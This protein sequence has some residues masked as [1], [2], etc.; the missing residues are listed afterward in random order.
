MDHFKNNIQ[1]NKVVK[2]FPSDTLQLYKKNCKKN[3]ELMDSLGWTKDNI[4]YNFDRF[5]FR[6]HGK[7]DLA[8]EY[9]VILG[10][11]HTFGIGV[12]ENCTWY[13][14]LKDKFDEPFYNAAVPGGSIGACTRSLMGLQKLGMKIKRVFVLLPDK[15]R[16]EVFDGVNWNVISWWTGH[17]K[18]VTNLCT[19]ENTLNLFHEVNKLAIQKICNDQKIEL[20]D[21]PVDGKDELDMLIC[22]DKRARDLMHPGIDAHKWIGERFYDE[23]CKRYGSST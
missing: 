18:E 14:V 2:W 17:S 4:I 5:G 11:S 6:N 1:P 13:N 10:C 21:I 19:N 7:L 20:V 12:P 9:N 15:T 8:M 22:N 23:Y 3:Q 16:F